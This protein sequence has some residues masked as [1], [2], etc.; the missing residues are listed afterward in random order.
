MLLYTLTKKFMDTCYIHLV[1]YCFIKWWG[2]LMA[3]TLVWNQG[4]QG[5]I[6]FI[7]KYYMWNMYICIYTL[8][9]CVNV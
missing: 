2:G 4:D 9:M 7:N 8:Y 1:S 3:K 5:S 6:P